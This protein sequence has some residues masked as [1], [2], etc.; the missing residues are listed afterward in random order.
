MQCVHIDDR[1]FCFSKKYMIRIQDVTKIIDHRSLKI[2]N[3]WTKTPEW[4]L[5]I[6]TVGFFVLFY[7][8]VEPWVDPARATRVARTRMSCACDTG[9][10]SVM[11]VA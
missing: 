8:F 9:S 2:M 4:L 3:T 7:M 10:R 6:D 11:S 5:H 1:V